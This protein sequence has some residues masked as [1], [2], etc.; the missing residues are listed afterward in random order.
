MDVRRRDPAGHKRWLGL[1]REC[2]D[3]ELHHYGER[4]EGVLPTYALTCALRKRAKGRFVHGQVSDRFAVLEV[5]LAQLRKN[6]QQEAR[7]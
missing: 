4:S 6:D 2:E 7:K 5:R 3:A 1:A